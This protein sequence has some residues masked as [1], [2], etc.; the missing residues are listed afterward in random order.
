MTQAIV[1]SDGSVE[2]DVLTNASEAS[3]LPEIY[4]LTRDHKNLAYA[5]DEIMDDP[6][7]A[8]WAEFLNNVQ[9]NGV[10][11]GLVQ[12][13]ATS[14]KLDEYM[15]KTGF[16]SVNCE[17]PDLWERN[18]LER[19]GIMSEI[20]SNSTYWERPDNVKCP[21]SSDGEKLPALVLEKDEAYSFEE[22]KEVY[23]SILNRV[24][25]IDVDPEDQ[26][27][28]VE[29]D[30]SNNGNGGSGS[31]EEDFFLNEVEKV[32][33][34]TSDNLKEYLIENRVTLDWREEIDE[35]AWNEADAVITK[36]EARDR[37]QQV[38]LDMDSE[39]FQKAMQLIEEGETAQAMMAVERYE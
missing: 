30:G 7:A 27:D 35:D 1:A 15:R 25:G 13:K 2:V 36:E 37:L 29:T 8:K 12:A 3:E 21:I 31:D 26:D 39:K 17:Q 11:I 19:E 34:A 9:I 14:Y 38:A 28:G 24:P 16:T 22:A 23:Y 20:T 6:E 10:D 18:E 32:G 33:P 4:D 5:V